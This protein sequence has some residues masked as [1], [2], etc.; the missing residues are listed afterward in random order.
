MSEIQADSSS[1]RGDSSEQRATLEEAPWRILFVDDD[2]DTLLVTRM[3]FRN[4]KILGRQV[5][6]L[7]ARSAAEARQI[8]STP[9][10]ELAVVVTDVVMENIDSGL[11]LLRWIR[12]QAH[13]AEV[14]LVVRTGQPGLAP[15]QQLLEQLDI[16]DYW[17]KAAIQTN[18]LRTIVT[19]LFRSFRDLKQLRQRQAQT[20]RVVRYLS[21]MLSANSVQQIIR[22]LQQNIEQESTS[23][24]SLIAMLQRSEGKATGSLPALFSSHAPGAPQN[25]PGLKLQLSDL[26]S[27]DEIPHIESSQKCQNLVIA[28]KHTYLFL[29]ISEEHAALL[30]LQRLTPVAGPQRD[31]ILLLFGSAIGIAY[32]K[33]LGDQQNRSLNE[34]TILLREVHHRVKNNLQ[35][36]SSLLSL[37]REKMSGNNQLIFD[38]T[39]AR[40]HSIALIHQ[41]L[42]GS[43]TLASIQL[44][45]YG[46]QLCTMLCETLTTTGAVRFHGEPASVTIEQA[47]P[48]GLIL[49]ELVTNALKYGQSNKDDEPIEVSVCCV[50]DRIVAVVQD[51]GEGMPERTSSDKLS[52]SLGLSLVDSLTRQLRGTIE[53]SNNPGARIQLSFPLADD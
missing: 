8:L 26:V 1:A 24:D 46:R 45:Q 42:Y 50:K 43:Q 16:N 48:F 11:E 22:E 9:D 32:N 13:L 33:Y 19:G 49:N 39:I 4:R 30:R 44:D 31:A 7:E 27:A 18:R 52:E 2:A 41:Q 10:K 51:H 6:V 25:A 17:N 5:D 23:R 38:E 3:A 21:S 40:I 53:F 15:E 20:S 36:V 35:I 34:K 47:I 12:K 37:Q 28:G 29:S 14:R